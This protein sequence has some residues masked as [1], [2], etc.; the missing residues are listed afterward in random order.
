M[1]CLFAKCPRMNEGRFLE[2][3]S[4]LALGYLSG[5]LRQHGYQVNFINAAL[6]NFSPQEMVNWIIKEN[7][8]LIGFTVPDVTLVEP[9]IAIV[10]ALRK[11]GLKR[12]ITIG[13]HAATFHCRD[14]LQMCP[15]IDSVVLF[16]G[17]ETISELVY[18][19]RSGKEWRNIQGIAY[20]ENGEV[21]TT[22]RRQFIRDLDEIPFP[23]RDDLP[24]VLENL[25]DTGAVPILSSR[26]CYFNCGF[27]SVR[28]FYEFDGHPTWRRRSVGNVLEEIQYLIQRYSVN[29]ILFVDDLFMSKSHTSKVYAEEFAKA[30]LDHHLRLIFTI[31]AT[32][33]SIDK[34]IFELLREA[35][36]RQVFL[37][38]ESASQEIL[39]YLN[40]WFSPSDIENAVETLLDLDIDPSVSFINFT[41]KYLDKI[42]FLCLPR[43]TRNT[44]KRQ[45]LT[46]RGSL[47]PLRLCGET[48]V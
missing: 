36:L 17:E 5:V 21:R 6:R 37:G 46:R 13:G 24:F 9:T 43:N 23:A 1:S 8:D 35:G 25:P 40:K 31:S 33:D 48:A 16:E 29:E 3:S 20:R 27:C 38:A 12:H 11:Q 26:G 47:R 45:I 32:V 22:G 4:S 14:I 30:V 18:A 28:A 34:P 2:N 7:Y 15:L 10:Q 39:E 41:P 44:R 19:I 42:I